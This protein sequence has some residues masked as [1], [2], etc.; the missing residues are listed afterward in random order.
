MFHSN[1]ATEIGLVPQTRKMLGDDRKP[2]PELAQRDAESH[3]RYEIG[4]TEFL[5][6][7]TSTTEWKTF[8]EIYKVALD[9]DADIDERS[10]QSTLS[11]A[12]RQGWFESKHEGRAKYRRI[13][14]EFVT[15]PKPEGKRGVPFISF[16][17]KVTSV[18]SW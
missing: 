3:R 1:K 6:N 7:F 12:V 14:G 10:M 11:S 15:Q 13:E 5:K 4:P 18:N 17:R 8:L 16:K 2:L 9:M